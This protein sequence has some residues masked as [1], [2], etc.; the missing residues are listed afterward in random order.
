M[1][2][3]LLALISQQFPDRSRNVE[4]RGRRQP[5]QEDLVRPKVSF[6]KVD[7][8]VEQNELRL[9]LIARIVIV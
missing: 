4:V 9:L 3:V 2:F 6:A 8:E 1:I 7:E 5:S